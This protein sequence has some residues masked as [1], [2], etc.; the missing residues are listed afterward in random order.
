ML[1]GEIVAEGPVAE[2]TRE[3]VLDAYFGL[4]RAAGAHA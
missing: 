1:E 2:M 3:R 4:H